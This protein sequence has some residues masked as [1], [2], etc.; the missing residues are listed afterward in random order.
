MTGRDIYLTDCTLK[1]Q[2]VNVKHVNCF[3]DF[4]N[5]YSYLV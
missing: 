5:F 4:I 2:E 3:A 1:I